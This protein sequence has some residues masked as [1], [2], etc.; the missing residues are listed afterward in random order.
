DSCSKR[1][2]RTSPARELNWVMRLA[3]RL[4]SSLASATITGVIAA[5]IGVPLCQK[6]EV[7][8]AAVSEARLATIRV[9]NDSLEPPSSFGRRSC[10]ADQ[11]SECA[12]RARLEIGDWRLG[13]PPSDLQSPISY[14]VTRICN[15]L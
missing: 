4:Y 7:T 8:I 11:G 6:V 14:L 12:L 3:G 5:V 9:C 15:T 10:T 13:E 1:R 2:P